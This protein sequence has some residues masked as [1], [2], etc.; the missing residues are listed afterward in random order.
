MIG[1]PWRELE[2]TGSFLT[3]GN[4]IP[5][6]SHTKVS[7][8]AVACQPYRLSE[9]NGPRCF[10]RFCV[11][12][13]HSEV[14]DAGTLANPLPAAAYATQA[15]DWADMTEIDPSGRRLS[16]KDLSSC[17]KRADSRD[18]RAEIWPD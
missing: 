18:P 15:S 1:A 10:Q 2:V 14:E 7:F 13:R 17:E 16:V 3:V 6:V 11:S 8:R 4:L 12:L 9:P 5:D